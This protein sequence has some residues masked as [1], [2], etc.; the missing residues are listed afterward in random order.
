MHGTSG[1]A[2]PDDPP[3]KPCAD[4]RDRAMA[5]HQETMRQFLQ[6]QERLM[7]AYLGGASGGAQRPARPFSTPRPMAPVAPRPAMPA[8]VARPAAPTLTSAQRVSE[9]APP[10]P[11]AATPVDAKAQLLAIAADR[12]G[13]PEDMLG[14]DMDLEADLGIDSI[15]RVEILGAFRKAQ[16]E[17]VSAQLQP[18][19]EQ[20]AKAKTLQEVLDRIASALAAPA[21]AAPPVVTAATEI[22]PPFDETGSGPRAAALAR[23][24]MRADAEALPPGQPV[25]VA[26]GLYLI[27]PDRL[28]V[29][30]ALAALLERDGAQARLVP[31][32]LATDEA[33]LSAWLRDQRAS[34]ICGLIALGAMLPPENAP[35]DAANWHAGMETCVKSLFPLLRRAAADLAQGLIVVASAM[36][37]RFGRDALSRTEAFFPG[38]GGGVGLV[39]TLAME[40]ERC[41]CK[42][43]DLDLAEDAAAL[44][45]HLHA[46][47]AATAGRREVGYPAGVRTIF[48]TT[49]APLDRA[50]LAAVRPDKAW[51]VLAVGGARGITA[52]TLRPFAAAGATCVLVSRSA[53]PGP[54]DATTAPHADAT[55]LRRHF[56]TDAAAA[57]T[58]PTPAKIEAKVQCVLRDREIRANVADFEVLGATL[59]ARTC[60]V[61][62]EGQ[63]AGLLDA[64]YARH[65]RIDAV[66]L[67]AGLI[68]DRLIVDKTRESL[69]RVFD[70][71]VDGAFF[72]AKHLRPE[73]LKFLAL[74]SSVAGRYG[75]RGQAD[76]AAANEVLNRLA[77]QLQARFGAGVKV[78][79]VNWGAWARTTNGPG[80]L[81]PETTRQF[82]ERG[83][84]LI[85]PKAGGRVLIDELLFAPPGEVEIV[86]GEHEWDAWEDVAGRAAPDAG[87]TSIQASDTRASSTARRVA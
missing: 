68:E 37:G 70:T 31:D 47:I 63:V 74:F 25:T 39:K 52:E 75:N 84:K 6:M 13:Y 4:A 9:A 5:E 57:G 33:A 86:A 38:E 43:I 51:V 71:K 54:E 78:V 66:L 58:R 11:V 34:R 82:R 29:A 8:P 53:L 3:D 12:T 67:G 23:Y 64:V 80:M 27:L 83:L 44:A 7:L 62:D 19:M 30:E 40:W 21:S 18:H 35:R 56:L 41:R 42:A 50:A 55:A 36:G 24:V 26:P 48:R 17:A 49:P 79:S 10:P 32:G 45:K 46:E 28:G 72:F 15:K 65:G 1:P 2:Q 20:V 69:D 16:P 77:W 61:R 22:A 60:D 14:L 81:T 73:T 76:Y 87:E 85:E 59:D